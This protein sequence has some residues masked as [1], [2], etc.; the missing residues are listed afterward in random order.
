MNESVEIVVADR[1]FTV[2]RTAR[3]VDCDPAGVVYAGRYPDYLLGAVGHFLRALRGAPV[4]LAPEVDLICK[5]MALTFQASLCPDDVVDIRLGIGQVR[6]HSFDIVAE[7]RRLD[8]RSA[9]GGVFTPICVPQGRL[10]KK[11]PIPPALRQALERQ[12]IVNGSM[13]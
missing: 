4:A 11:A 1:P 5:H 7:A 10:D 12:L 3:W 2:R 13:S 9:F 6:E 8:G